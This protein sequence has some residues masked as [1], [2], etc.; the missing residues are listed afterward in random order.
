[1]LANATFTN[2]QKFLR[3]VKSHFETNE[4]FRWVFPELIPGPKEKWTESEICVPRTN[5]VKESSVEAIGVG[6]TAVGRHFRCIVKDDLVN[7]DHIISTDQMQ[8]VIDWHKYSASLLVHPGRDREHV[9][10]TRWAFYDVY[11]YIKENEIPPFQLYE[12][13]AIEYGESIFPEE[14]DLQTLHDLELRQGPYIFSCQYLNAPVDPARTIIK[15]EWLQYIED[16]KDTDLK[17]LYSQCSCYLIIDP[18]ISQK[19]HGDYTGL[20]L[21]YVDQHYDVYVEYADRQRISPDQ[22]IDLV[23]NMVSLHNPNS[24]GIETVQFARALKYSMEQAM[25]DRKK[26][27]YI[28]ELQPNTHQTKEMR[29]RASLQ[30][31]FAQRKVYIRK[32]QTALKD[33]LLKFPLGDH[34]DVVDAL[35]Y[36]PHMWT[37]GPGPYEPKPETSKDPFNM[38]YILEKLQHSSPESNYPFVLTPGERRHWH[39]RN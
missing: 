33:E 28:Q 26:W 20:I 36:L 5:E 29:V 34:D 35:A 10:G 30:P 39:A 17:K 32:S 1:M 6:G 38:S 27:F 4:I 13:P 24:V 8:K 37:A 22:M 31:L 16:L 15:P 19:R 11:S 18:A 3:V 9:Q 7:E 12:R 23:F 21:A 2:A 25:R 14:F